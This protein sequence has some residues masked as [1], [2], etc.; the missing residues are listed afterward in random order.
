MYGYHEDANGFRFYQKTV[1]LTAAC[2]LNTRYTAEYT[3][4]NIQKQDQELPDALQFLIN[5]TLS[6][7]SCPVN[8]AV[9]NQIISLLNQ[10][11][12]ALGGLIEIVSID[13]GCDTRSSSLTMAIGVIV[14]DDGQTNST[15]Y[16]EAIESLLI[17]GNDTLV[18]NGLID[19][20]VDET[21]EAIEDY[22]PQEDGVVQEFEFEL[23]SMDSTVSKTR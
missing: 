10:V 16:Y 11:L 22:V 6:G 7:F 15:Q 1:G 5:F 9:V 4:N 21:P 12:A 2:N 13:T 18:N 14:V 19:F 20:F 17:A 3:F 8:D 23:V